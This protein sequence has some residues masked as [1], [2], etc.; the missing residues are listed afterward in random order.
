L[1]DAHFVADSPLQ[2]PQTITSIAAADGML[3]LWRN[4]WFGIML[5]RLGGLYA[6]ANAEF[7][8]GAFTI[9][10]AT[11][12][13]WLNMDNRAHLGQ[14]GLGGDMPD[15][16]IMVALLPAGSDG[17]PPNHT[18][19]PGFEAERCVLPKLSQQGYPLSWKQDNGTLLSGGIL[20]GT[21]VRARIHMRKATVYGIGFGNTWSV[22]AVE[23]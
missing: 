12:H 23:I 5:F 6:P 15:S 2:V 17:S 7:S 19:I 3:W 20:S 10:A 9:P 4:S 1:H 13:L 8:S 11:K 22:A 21:T 16:Y 18:A 14:T